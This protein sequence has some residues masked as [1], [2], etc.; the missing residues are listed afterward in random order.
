MEIT[1]I[2]RI[3]IKVLAKRRRDKV[4]IEINKY[5]NDKGWGK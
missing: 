2:W 4:K 5:R 1:I 3:N